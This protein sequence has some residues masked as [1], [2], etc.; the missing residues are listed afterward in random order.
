MYDN[1]YVIPVYC[2]VS[3]SVFVYENSCL[4]QLQSLQSL[5]GTTSCRT[6]IGVKKVGEL[7]PSVFLSLCKRK[8][9]AA[10][11]EAESASLC[12]K[13]QNEIENPEWQPFKVIIVD[14]K[15]SVRWNLCLLLNMYLYWYELFIMEHWCCTCLC[16]KYS[17]RM[18]GSSEN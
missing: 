11:A 16:R 12:S 14:G 10:D 8:F 18:T 5:P 4:V 15:A 6:H 17:R 1:F 3:V 13:W 9:P 7:D 2:S